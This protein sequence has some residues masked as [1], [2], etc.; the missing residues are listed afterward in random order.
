MSIAIIT[1]KNTLPYFHPYSVFAIDSTTNEKIKLGDYKNKKD[2]D[3]ERKFFD[4]SRLLGI[5]YFRKIKKDDSHTSDPLKQLEKRI[6]NP[7]DSPHKPLVK[8]QRKIIL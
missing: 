8:K 3:L 1:V 4:L 2:A 7:A 5:E 6:K